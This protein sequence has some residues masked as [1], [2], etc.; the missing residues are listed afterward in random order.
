M[1]QTSEWVSPGHPDKVAD[2]ISSRI[3]DYC[4][5]RDPATRFAVECQIK[6]NRVALGGEV[7]SKALLD[8]HALAFL[9][10]DAVERIGY[11]HD[12]HGLWGLGNTISPH[13]LYVTAEI[14]L[15]SPDI[16]Q[17]VSMDGGWG[18]QGIFWGMATPEREFGYLP[19]DYYCARA[20]GQHLYALSLQRGLPIGLDIKTQVETCDALVRQVIVAA[21]CATDS[22]TDLLRD[23][24]TAF[25]ADWRTAPD[26]EIV[27]N[28]TGRY[29]RHASQGDCGTTGRKLAVDFYGGNCRI[30]GG[31][32]WTKDPSKAD[33]TL[34]L[35][36]RKLAL[37][38]VLSHQECPSSVYV[39]LSCCI[40]RDEVRVAF[41]DER[42][43]PIR[44]EHQR[45]SAPAHTVAAEL[46]LFRPAYFE[47]CQRGLF[48]EVDRA[49]AGVG[50]FDPARPVLPS[51]R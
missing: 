44:T 45:I 33:L 14:G 32:P 5:E 30:G 1:T 47:L 36:A 34:N 27:V 46:D 22:A 50:P 18:D 6:G 25:V 39:S 11:T 40:G 43:I 16:A 28:G 38:Y 42:H 31:S 4:L 51:G 21:P 8:S 12:Y 35:L 15:Q 9:A 26:C 2:A 49:F 17:G 24:I 37:E 48:S 3:L 23:E 13:D 41:C 20:L 10:R 19:R 29:V 7:T